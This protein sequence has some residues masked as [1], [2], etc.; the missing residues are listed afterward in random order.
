L[1]DG[2]V[3]PNVCLELG[4]MLALG[5]PCLLLKE[6]AVP[7]MQAD[8]GGH[9]YKEFD[10]HDIGTTV[11]QAVRSW[12][13]ELDIAK[14]KGERLLIFVSEGGTCRDPMAKAILEQLLGN[15]R[16][17]LGIRIE[18]MARKPPSGPGASRGARVAIQEMFGEDLLAEHRT[19][20]LTDTF[21]EEADLILV[22]EKTHLKGLPLKKS[23]TLREFLLGVEG[24]IADPWSPL[25]EP[26]LNAYRACAAEIRGLLEAGIERI[27]ETLAP[28]DGRNDS[29]A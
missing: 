19:A 12:L 21:E 26:D 18:A 9:L 22:M 25:P 10:A 5:R 24:D 17:E 23:H 27:V 4:Y 7:E 8:L 3:S 6:R 14:R 29:P 15:R 20:R 28:A 2:E 13:Q 1:T 11:S 16:R